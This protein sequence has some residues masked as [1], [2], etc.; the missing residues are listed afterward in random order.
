M[1]N[2]TLGQISTTLAFI[3]AFISSIAY[4]KKMLVNSIDKTLKPINKKIDSLELSSVKTDLVNF[5]VLAEQGQ[6][7]REQIMNA[8][9]LFDRYD[10]LGGN[11][12]VHSK[13]ERLKKEGKL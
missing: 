1:G 4:L 13:W 10:K 9:E 2:V 8:Y 7:S 3:V 12:Y 11:G 5:L 6:A